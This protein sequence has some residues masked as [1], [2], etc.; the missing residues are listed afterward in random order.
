MRAPHVRVFSSRAGRFFRLRQGGLKIFFARPHLFL[1][2]RWQKHTFVLYYQKNFLFARRT[3]VYAQPVDNSVRT[4]RPR[5][6][7]KGV[8]HMNIQIFAKAKC[9]DSKK[10]ERWFKERGIKYQ[11]VDLVRYGMSGGEFAAVSRAVGGFEALIDPKSKD[12]KS[13]SYLAYDADKAA[14]LLEDPRLLRTPIVRNGRQ[15]TV[16]YCPEVWQTWADA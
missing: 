14:R 5:A 9:F 6:H 13:L 15:A 10:A 2:I 11:L 4:A 16:G 12:A 7:K 8:A 1:F 3:Q